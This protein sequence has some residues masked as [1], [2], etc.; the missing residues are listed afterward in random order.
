MTAPLGSFESVLEIDGHC[1]NI[2]VYV[3]RVMDLKMSM[4]VGN[5]ILEAGADFRI[6]IIED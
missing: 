5:N 2:E 3:C 4:I 6:S 1:F